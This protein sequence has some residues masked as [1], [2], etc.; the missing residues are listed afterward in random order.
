VEWLIEGVGLCLEKL[1]YIVGIGVV[2]A[3]SL[4]LNAKSTKYQV[5]SSLFRMIK[6]L[7]RNGKVN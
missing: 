2:R 3:M 6:W 7:G 4:W 5:W 1:T